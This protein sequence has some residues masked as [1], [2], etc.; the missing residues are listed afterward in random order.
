MTPYQCLQYALDRPAVVSCLA[1]AVTAEEMA[2]TLRYYETSEAER[3]YSF[4]KTLRKEDLPNGCTYCGHCL[5]YCPFHVDVPA[6]MKEID[7][8][9]KTL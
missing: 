8:Y 9:F 1:G 5:E 7:E 2:E 4:I 3:D 6:R